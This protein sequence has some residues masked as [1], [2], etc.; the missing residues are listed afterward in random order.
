MRHFMTLISIALIAISCGNRVD[1]E[2]ITLEDPDG[3]QVPLSWPAEG[4]FDVYVFLSPECPLCQNY[5]KNLEEIQ[6]AY[7]DQG[8]R[9]LGIFPGLEYPLKDIMQYRE[10]YEMSIPFLLDPDFEL[11]HALKA[12]ITPEVVLIDHE[13]MIRYQ[14]GIDDWAVT[15]RKHRQVITYNYLTDA[16]DACLAGEEVEVK[17][18]EAVGCFIQ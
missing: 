18:T 1:I 2:Q 10:D 5:S 7:L 9:I 15:V 16:I 8:V 13:G 14:G 3:N 12:E 11:T 4:R 6:T 17:K